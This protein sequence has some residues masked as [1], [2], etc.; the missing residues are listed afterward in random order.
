MLVTNITAACT[1]AI[2]DHS[3]HCYSRLSLLITAVTAAR[4]C[5]CLSQ[6]AQLIT[7]VTLRHNCHSLPQLPL[8]ATAGT[9]C[10]S[11][12]C[13]LDKL[14]LLREENSAV[15]VLWSPWTPSLPVTVLSTVVPLLSLISLIC[16][17]PPVILSV[18]DSRPLHIIS[19][20]NGKCLFIWSINN[21]NNYCNSLH[22]HWHHVCKAFRSY[23]EMYK[24]IR[25]GFL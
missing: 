25:G 2:A 8:V 12:H 23:K 16:P 18:L 5:H 11:C 20:R 13:M 21:S 9:A 22:I 10:H 17:A 7:T 4:S 3:C 6:L 15:R 1:A 24:T 14:L 19:Y